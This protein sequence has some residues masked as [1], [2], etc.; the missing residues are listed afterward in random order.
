MTG[1]PTLNMTGAATLNMTNAGTLDLS[2]PDDDFDPFNPALHMRLL[3]GL[4]VPV[5][6]RHGYLR[7]PGKLPLVRAR[8]VVQLGQDTFY[9]SDCKGEG[10]FAKVW[11]ATRQDT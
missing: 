6:Q 5:Y 3:A 10:G 11:A 4:S 2:T 7:L 1:A 9:V 8:S